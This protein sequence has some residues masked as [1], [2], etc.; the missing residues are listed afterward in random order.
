MSHST[1]CD[2]INVHLS[3]GSS[4]LKV[5]WWQPLLGLKGTKSLQA[6]SVRTKLF[7]LLK[8]SG[9]RQKEQGE[10]DQSG[11]GIVHVYLLVYVGS[12]DF[13]K[14]KNNHVK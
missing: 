9:H 11:K 12:S 4:Y 2:A 13:Q 10:T 7:V 8:T 3:L 6:Q 1:V 14:L 5:V